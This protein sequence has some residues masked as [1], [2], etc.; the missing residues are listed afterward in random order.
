MVRLGL[1]E[2]IGAG[3]RAVSKYTGTVFAVFLAQMF[4]ALACMFAIA[5]VLAQQFAHLPMFD[6]A[7]GGDLVSLVYC[8]K[9][10][11][12]SFLAVGGIVFAALVLWQLASWFLVGG[13][14]GVLAQRPDGRGDTVRVFG[15]SGAT[16]YLTYAR[17]ALCSL[18]GWII[19]L[20]VWGL[21]MG[22]VAPH[23]QHALT[24]TQLFGP[25]LLA[26]LPALLLLHFFWTVTDY[27][28][29]ELTLRQATHDPGVIATYLRTVRY[30]VK[31][32]ITLLHAGVGWI[33]LLLV[34]LLYAYL[35][36]GHPMYGADGAVML[37]FLRQGVSLL[38]MAIR[39]GVLAGQV[40]LGRTRA[41][42]P[43]PGPGPKVEAKTDA[44]G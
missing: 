9:F 41:L 5:V 24:L 38:R 12:P 30:V 10:G 32:P 1:R 33:A 3:G 43:K 18:P 15:A 37:F 23:V 40:E 25:L 13:L 42:P 31:R 35:A 44:K 36:H 7:V 39:V 8:L 17:L 11:K 27:A 26:S 29:V 4:V 14:Y 28:R 21:G 2:L 20:F 22:T 16:T 34:T 6:K 19:V